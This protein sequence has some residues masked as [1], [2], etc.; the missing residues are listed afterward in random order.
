M[1]YVMALS[2]LTLVAC[3]GEKNRPP[4]KE[5]VSTTVTTTSAALSLP[6]VPQAAPEAEAPAPI[7]ATKEGDRS[8]GTK[9]RAHLER[10][11][12][13]KNVRWRRVSMEIA[14]GHVTLRGNLPTVADSTEMERSV[15][16][17][18][19]VSGVTNDIEENDRR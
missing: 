3:G 2:V 17:V 10:D 14:D 18:K 6:V 8:L 12:A 19:G 11:E 9:I 5:P 4:P 1:R 15:R 16:E 7:I 13:L